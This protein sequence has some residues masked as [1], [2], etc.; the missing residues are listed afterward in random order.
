VLRDWAAEVG[1]RRLW[2]PGAVIALPPFGGGEARARCTGCRVVLTDGD[3]RFWLGVRQLGRFPGICPLCGSDL[4]QWTVRQ[5]R[6]PA[7]DPEPMPNA[8]SAACT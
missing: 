3:P 2:L 8:R 6:A 7:D 4:P 5:A 1:Y